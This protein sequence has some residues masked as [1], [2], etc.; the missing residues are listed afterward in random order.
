[1]LSTGCAK[2]ELT[3]PTAPVHVLKGAGNGTVTPG[4]VHSTGSSITDDGD[5]QGDKE[6]SNSKP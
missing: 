4:D 6:H 5:D 1:M 3:A 2:E